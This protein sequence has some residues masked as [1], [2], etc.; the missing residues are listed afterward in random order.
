MT[1][2]EIKKHV[3]ISLFGSFI[4]YETFKELSSI[5]TTLKKILFSD[6]FEN[7]NSNFFYSSKIFIC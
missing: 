6:N 2:F 7:F 3:Y 4:C 5:V 1:G